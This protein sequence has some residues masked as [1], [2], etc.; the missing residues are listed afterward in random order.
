MIPGRHLTVMD[1][2]VPDVR[3]AFCSLLCCGSSI[4]FFLSSCHWRWR[5]ACREGKLAQ[6]TKRTRNTSL[7]TNVCV[8]A[9]ALYCLLPDT[10]HHLAQIEIYLT[11]C[12][13]RGVKGGSQPEKEMETLSHKAMKEIGT[14]QTQT[15]TCWAA[16]S[17][18]MVSFGLHRRAKINVCSR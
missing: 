5:C 11:R 10:S 2:S 9:V 3:E 7:H 4:S 1:L 6:N 14:S 15:V 17:P 8:P 12:Q 13:H 18:T 16:F